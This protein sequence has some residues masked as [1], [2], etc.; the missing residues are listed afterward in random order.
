M[1]RARPI[2]IDDVSRA[3]I[4]E[5]QEDGRRSYADIA[6]AVGLSEAAVRQRV[7][8]LLASGAIRIAAT[9]D[10]ARLGLARAAMIGVRVTGDA[11]GVADAIRRIPSVGSIVLTAGSLDILAE[12]AC[13]H[14]DDLVALLDR[15]RA[16][17]G[18]GS[19][20]TFPYLR[21]V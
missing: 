10:P 8:R 2:A 6:K 3:I 15:I 16:I 20:E 5:L 18:V 19:T 1:P 21:R 9:T 11:T 13:A 12:V 7:Q 14:D 17:D 4:A